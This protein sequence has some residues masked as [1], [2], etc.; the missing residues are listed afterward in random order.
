MV[1]CFGKSGRLNQV[2]SLSIIVFLSDALKIVVDAHSRVFDGL[3]THIFN[4]QVAYHLC[5]I[6]RSICI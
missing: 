2:V 1:T 5:H 6:D 3:N 4:E